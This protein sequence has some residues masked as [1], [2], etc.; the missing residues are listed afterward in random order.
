M[1][2]YET[3]EARE[4]KKSNENKIRTLNSVTL[5]NVQHEE[6]F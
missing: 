4:S 1:F 6:E 2:V 3:F 5:I